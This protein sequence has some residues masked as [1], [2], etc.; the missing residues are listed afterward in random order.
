MNNS[1]DYIIDNE[2]MDENYVSS[3]VVFSNVFSYT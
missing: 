2:I 3:A 1:L